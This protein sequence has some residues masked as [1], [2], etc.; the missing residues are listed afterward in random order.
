VGGQRVPGHSL[1][2]WDGRCPDDLVEAFGGLQAVMD[3]APGAAA[4]PSAPRT[5][6]DVRRSEDRELARGRYWRVC[7]RDDADGR[8]VGFTEL[9][10]TDARRIVADQGDTGVLRGHRGRGL[11]RWMKAANLLR[12]LDERPDVVAVDTT[13]AAGNEPS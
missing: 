1:V 12:L 3:D 13:M 11:A 9:Q 6:S 2:A 7:A 5:A 10:I 8:L 4:G